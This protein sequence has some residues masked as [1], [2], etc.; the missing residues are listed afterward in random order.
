LGLEIGS[1]KGYA[2]RGH[3]NGIVKFFIREQQWVEEGLV[4]CK[5]TAI[6]RW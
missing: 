1:P 4:E 3:V 2:W 6:Q 5:D